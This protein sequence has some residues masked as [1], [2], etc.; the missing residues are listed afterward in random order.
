MSKQKMQLKKPKSHAYLENFFSSFS[1]GAI[2]V[3]VLFMCNVSRPQCLPSSNLK[4][5]EIGEGSPKM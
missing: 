3:R 5:H 1:F 2:S 4:S